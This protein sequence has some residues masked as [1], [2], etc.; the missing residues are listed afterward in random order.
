MPPYL[1]TALAVLL[2]PPGPA[3]GYA[4][5]DQ[6]RFERTGQCPGGDL[7]DSAYGRRDFSRA[8]LQGANLSGSAFYRTNLQHANLR[9]ADL[10]GCVCFM[11]DFTGADLTG[12][13]TRGTLF[14]LCSGR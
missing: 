5:A 4:P 8:N 11:V 13:R 9:D 3:L 6:A 2:L 7:S 10:R 14:F 12:A 1:R